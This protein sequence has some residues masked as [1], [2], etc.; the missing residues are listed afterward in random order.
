M[1]H[2]W[3]SFSNLQKLAEQQERFMTNSNYFTEFFQLKKD[4]S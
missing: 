2:T 3:T 1:L 4:I